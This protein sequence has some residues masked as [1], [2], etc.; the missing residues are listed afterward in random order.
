[1]T[2]L[3]PVFENMKIVSGKI[4]GLLNNRSSIWKQ[5]WIYRVIFQTMAKREFPIELLAACIWCS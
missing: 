3:K 1:M 2:M 4:H 5:D